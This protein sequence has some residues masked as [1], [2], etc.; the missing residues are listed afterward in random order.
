MCVSHTT[1]VIVF[2]WISAKPRL[3]WKLRKS[4]DSVFEVVCGMI[5]FLDEIP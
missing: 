4:F 1:K 3:L 5:Q 2:C